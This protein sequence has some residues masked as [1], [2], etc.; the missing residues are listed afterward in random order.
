M[1]KLKRAC[2]EYMNYIMSDDY[3]EDTATDYEHY[4]FEKAMESIYG[5]DVW[6]TINNIL[7]RK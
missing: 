5:K 7:G 1:D 3:H 2:E 4:I 6:N